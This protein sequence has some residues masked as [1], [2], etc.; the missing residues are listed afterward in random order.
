LIY[1][2]ASRVVFSKTTPPDVRWLCIT[3]AIVLSAPYI[4]DQIFSG[5]TTMFYL[6]LTVAGFVWA[7]EAKA[8]RAGASLGA[9][10][11]LKLVPL[12]FVPWLLLCRRKG[13]GAAAFAITLA[14]LLVLPSIQSGWQRNIEFLRQLPGHMTSTESHEQDYRRQN[15]SVYAMLT[16]FLS[17]PP[18]P[19]T[20]DDYRAPAVNFATL[21]THTI[22]KIWLLLGIATAAVLYLWIVRETRHGRAD[23]GAILGLLLLFMTIFNP[24]AWRYTYSAVGIVYL[25]LLH[26][27]WQQTRRPKLVVGLI[28]ASCVLHF[29]PDFLQGLSARLWGAIGLAVAVLASHEAPG[30]RAAAEME[31]ALIAQDP[32]PALP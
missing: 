9:A 30:N 1:R 15:Q 11:V 23:P 8:V 13:R 12:A 28:A 24:L 3:G 26:R 19:K 31:P 29:A 20:P 25:Y 32:L 21:E 5:T 14:G 10:V 6:L 4:F 17:P 27:L 22:W 16:R 2:L 18:P 7:G